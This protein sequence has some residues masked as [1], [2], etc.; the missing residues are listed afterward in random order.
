[1]VDSSIISQEE[2]GIGILIILILRISGQK[3]R[4][5]KINSS[6]EEEFIKL[7]I[8]NTVGNEWKTNAINIHPKLISSLKKVLQ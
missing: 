3:Y 7:I 8:C 5:V 4:F 1:M 6:K 2:L